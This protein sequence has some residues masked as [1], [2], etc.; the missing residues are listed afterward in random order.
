MAPCLWKASHL[1]WTFRSTAFSLQYDSSLPSSH[2]YHGFK[3]SSLSMLSQGWQQLSPRRQTTTSGHK[4]FNANPT[5]FTPVKQPHR[6]KSHLRSATPVKHRNAHFPVVTSSCFTRALIILEMKYQC[7]HYEA[8]K[9]QG[10]KHES[11]WNFCVDSIS[12]Q[13]RG[14]FFFPPVTL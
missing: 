1:G 6:H 7:K 10:S 13:L 3:P 11:V 12:Q 9:K 8:L 14:L 2:F 4:P 5:L